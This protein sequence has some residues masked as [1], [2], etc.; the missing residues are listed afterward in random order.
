M[1]FVIYLLWCTIG[2]Q[3]VFS[4]FVQ[5]I[6]VG[7]ILCILNLISFV[8]KFVVYFWKSNKLQCECGNWTIN[9][10]EVYPFFSS[11]STYGDM[12]ML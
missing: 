2:T 6:W 12:Y 3:T 4:M 9:Q 11:L 5:M 7:Y 8:G 10:V 1:V